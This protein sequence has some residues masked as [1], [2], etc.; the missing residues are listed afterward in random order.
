MLRTLLASLA[1]AA[2]APQSDPGAAVAGVPTYTILEGMLR[3]A[4]DGA[5]E[6]LLRSLDL[7]APV[8]AEH[9]RLLGPRDIGREIGAARTPI[10]QRRLIEILVA[11][12]VATLLARTEREGVAARRRTLVKTARLEW[13]L[14]EA[15]WAR[16]DQRRAFELS[17]HFRDAGA[18][19]QAEDA[20]ALGRAALQLRMLLDALIGEG[21][22][23]ARE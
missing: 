7:L 8:L 9:D 3:F 2:A 18:A 19:A 22:G 1:I 6:K 5:A 23:R 13:S 12:D 17:A 10:E 16:R 21:P 4:D 11:R 15:A 20:E 14:V